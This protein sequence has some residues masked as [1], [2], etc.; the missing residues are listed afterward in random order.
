MLSALCSRIPEMEMVLHLF[1]T[2]LLLRLR[3]EVMLSQ[4]TTEATTEKLP[5]APKIRIV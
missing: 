3:M 5:L 1:L 2:V 4:L